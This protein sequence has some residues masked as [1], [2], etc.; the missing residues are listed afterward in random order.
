MASARGYNTNAERLT[1][2]EC[3]RR[4]LAALKKSGHRG[5]T[6]ADVG[7]QI[8]PDRRFDRRGAGG[9]AIRVLRRLARTGQA[10]QTWGTY[11]ATWLAV[12]P[13]VHAGSEAGT[14]NTGH[15]KDRST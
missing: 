5:L 2:E 3:E 14:A 12:E 9:A 6:A 7:F 1:A 10:Y 8:W 11:N 13:K 4:A 15:E